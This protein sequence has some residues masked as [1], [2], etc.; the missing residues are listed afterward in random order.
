MAVLTGSYLF[1]IDIDSLYTNIDTATGLQ[2]VASIFQKYPDSTRLDKEIIQLLTIYLN[3]NDFE[4][5]NKHFLQIHGTAMGQR[6]APSYANI[7][8]I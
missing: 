6:H 4:F 5:N 8:C 7:F 2:A 3:N 1:T